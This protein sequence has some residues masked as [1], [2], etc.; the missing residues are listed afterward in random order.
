MLL[1]K[2]TSRRHS[3]LVY[4]Q[5]GMCSYLSLSLRHYLGSFGARRLGSLGARHVLHCMLV[6]SARFIP[7]HSCALYIMARNLNTPWSLAVWHVPMDYR[8]LWSLRR[9]PLVSDSEFDRYDV[10]LVV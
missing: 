1:L 9:C 3:S 5:N 8:V 10:L 7:S 6:A 4:V 2:D